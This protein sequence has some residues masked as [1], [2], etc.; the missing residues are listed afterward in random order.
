MEQFKKGLTA[1]L[2]KLGLNKDYSEEIDG[3]F[4]KGILKD[5]MPYKALFNTF[6]IH[7]SKRS[8]LFENIMKGKYIFDL[9]CHLN[10]PYVDAD[11]N[12]DDLAC[13]LEKS[14]LNRIEYVHVERQDSKIFIGVRFNKNIYM[15]LKGSEVH[16]YLYPYRL[17]LFDKLVKITDY[18]F[19]QLLFSYTK[20][21]DV[22][23]KYAEFVEHLKTLK[24]PLSITFDDLL[25]E[26]TNILP[27][28]D[29]F[30]YLESSSQWPKDQDAIDCAKTAFYCQ[31]Y[32]K[33]KY[34]H[35]VSKEYC[36]F[37]YDEFYFK[38]RIL[39]KSDFSAKYKVLM[40]LGSAVN[41]LDED[42]HRKAHMA[43]TIFAR[44][45]LYPLCFD[46][47]FVD[48]ICLALG[49]GVIGDS[50][51][52]DNLLNFNFDIFGSSFDL[53]TLKLSKDGS[54]TKMLKICYTN[55]VFSLPLPDRQ[56]IEE[57][58]TKL[59]S[60]QIPEVLLDEDFI[61]QADHILD[62]DTSEYDIVL[63]KKYIPGFSEIIGNITDSF[64]LGTPEFKEFSKGILFKM[65]YFYYNSL[66]RM[67]FIKAKT[68]V[69]TDLF[70]N[71]LILE[72]SFE[73]I[74]INKQTKK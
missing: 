50:K 42:F 68:D 54:N 12:G 70:A 24:L 65:G 74:K 39:I 33:S 60:L 19:D 3:L 7:M 44:L 25:F 58:K 53:E 41:K 31:L 8:R 9:T 32:L 26:N 49:H 55:S 52:V 22:K 36:V 14:F 2:R 21:R 62:F 28:F 20:P 6:L 47:C 73:Y 61:L 56:I 69:D 18:T 48:V 27:I 66:S 17:L 46:D 71:L 35:S 40:G 10:S 23:V 43:K 51:F 34:R 63:S 4:E 64:D 45:G 16:E 59:R 57:T 11:P 72:T 5:G 1:N 37:K 30:I 13:K 38:V 67:L 15:E 29:V